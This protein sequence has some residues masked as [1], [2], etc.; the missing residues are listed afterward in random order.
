MRNFNRR[1]FIKGLGAV[2]ALVIAPSGI[3]KGFIPNAVAKVP[4][5]SNVG[6]SFVGSTLVQCFES[7][8]VKLPKGHIG[9]S[10]FAIEEQPLYRNISSLFGWSI[11]NTS[12]SL[13]YWMQNQINVK[14]FIEQQNYR[15]KILDQIYARLKLQWV[16]NEQSGRFLGDEDDRYTMRV[17][18]VEKKWGIAPKKFIQKQIQGIKTSKHKMKIILK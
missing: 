18:P 14:N 10:I 5:P 7:E 13:K 17:P 9:A 16:N 15:D 1:D 12:K 4:T 8:L 6:K 11:S 2:G 3:I